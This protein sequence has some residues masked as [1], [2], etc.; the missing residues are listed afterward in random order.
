MSLSN[1]QFFQQRLYF[2]EYMQALGF[3]NHDNGAFYICDIIAVQPNNDSIVITEGLE[4]DEDFRSVEIE[5][6][7]TISDGLAALKY[8]FN[9]EWDKE[10]IVSFLEE[11]I[12]LTKEKGFIEFLNA[13]TKS[14]NSS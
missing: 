9:D 6:P 13:R 14:K 5:F 4:E 10:S 7:K 2:D 3:A 8:I 1:D 12:E 11:Y